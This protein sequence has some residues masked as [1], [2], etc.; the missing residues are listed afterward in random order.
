MFKSVKKFLRLSRIP[1]GVSQNPYK[2]NRREQPSGDITDALCKKKIGAN[3]RIIPPKEVPLDKVGHEQ[4]RTDSKRDC[5]MPHPSYSYPCIKY[6]G[7]NRWQHES[8]TSCALCSE[9]QAC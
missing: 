1:F 5:K 9:A 2:A 4:L 8:A 7:C 3:L 6:S